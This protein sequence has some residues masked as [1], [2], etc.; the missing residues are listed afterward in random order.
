MQRLLI[1][2]RVLKY[3][4][5]HWQLSA[6]FVVLGLA[7]GVASFYGLPPVRTAMFE[8]SLVPKASDNPMAGF[9]NENVSFFRATEQNFKS[10]ALIEETL[11]EMGEAEVHEGRLAGTQRRLEFRR[12][13]DTAAPTQTDARRCQAPTRRTHGRRCC[14]GG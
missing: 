7:L 9:R 2:K 14:R 13:G 11:R 6:T 3:Y 4:K 8:L 12:V 5:P 10:L 1:A